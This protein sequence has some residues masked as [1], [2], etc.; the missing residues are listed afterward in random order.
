MSAET[1]IKKINGYVGYFVDNTHYKDVETEY[2]LSRPV[3][4]I[5]LFDNKEE[6]LNIAHEEDKTHIKASVEGLV[7]KL[8]S[9]TTGIAEK[10]DSGKFLVIIEER[11]LDMIDQGGF[12]ILKEARAIKADE[13]NCVTISI[14]VGKGASTIKESVNWANQA[15]DMCLGRGGD[16]AAVKSPDGYEF[17][18]GVSKTIEKKG[19][20]RARIY[21]KALLRLIEQCDKLY[22]M[23]H[24]ASDIDSVGACIGVYA[25]AKSLGKEARI[26]ID[27]STTLAGRLVDRYAEENKDKKVFMSVSKAL[28]QDVDKALLVIVDAHSPEILDSKEFYEMF[29]GSVSIIDHHRKSVNYI[30]ENLLSFHESSASSACEMVTDV[31][32]CINEKCINTLEAEAL[33]AG[34]TLDTKNFTVGTGVGTFETAAFLRSKGAE[35]VEARK[36][37]AG[38][39]D[40]YK[41]KLQFVMAAEMV[42]NCAVSVAEVDCESTRIAASQAADELLTIQDID[43]SFVIFSSDSTVIVSARSYGKINVQLIMEKLGG[44]GHS[45]MAGAQIKNA[46]PYE[47]KDRIVE[48]IESSNLED[49]K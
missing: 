45:T 11:H 13:R 48:I 4:M 15:L 9:E 14:G 5:I 47:V 12:S 29:N 20:V 19:R 35:T 23:G 21:G 3:A 34:I 6:I 27:R 32:Q 46:D 41:G 26:V 16:Q 39:M 36:I 37:F 18:G 28:E 44:G 7:N 30:E 24:K 31:I 22:V 10:L 8:V 33:L 49:D 43:A 17:F 42:K 25:L 2:G 40:T 38:S 1:V